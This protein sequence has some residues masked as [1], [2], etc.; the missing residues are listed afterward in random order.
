MNF[1]NTSSQRW[2]SKIL[3]FALLI[4]T[5]IL[6]TDAPLA[7]AKEEK[8][9]TIKKFSSSL[10]SSKKVALEWS[11]VEDADGYAIYKVNKKDAKYEKNS[12]KRYTIVGYIKDEKELNT[13]VSK[14]TKGERNIYAIRAYKQLKTKKVFSERYREVAATV[15][16]L[17]K[18]SSKGFEDTTA[19]KII[20]L[21][22]TKLGSPYRSGGVGPNAFDCSG[23][24][25]YVMHNAE[26]DTIDFTRGSCAGNLAQ[27][28]KYSIGTTDLSKAQP[29]DIVFFS[30]YG[31]VSH[32]AIYHGNGKIIHA[33]NYSKPLDITTPAYFGSIAS[34]V[35]LPNL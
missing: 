14:V 34:I 10:Y 9:D 26:I 5:L 20:E 16:S 11:K 21:A 13:V 19:A 32:V 3:L 15:P 2:L 4:I 18:P 27:L 12:P 24:V 1:T 23:F 25:W 6:T 8:L 28:K 33:Q 7:M 29:G 30:N 31:Y 35:R 17:L 22:E